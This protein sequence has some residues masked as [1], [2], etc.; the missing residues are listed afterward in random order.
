MTADN[1]TLRNVMWTITYDTPILD[2]SKPLDFVAGMQ[3]TAWI[4][5]ATNIMTGFT[6]NY[7]EEIKF[8]AVA[9]KEK[10]TAKVGESFAADP[11]TYVTNKAGTPR[12]CS[13]SSSDGQSAG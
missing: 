12:G 5:G 13:S 10:Y 7:I 11:A 8:Q 3:G 1:N 4:G 2:M 6:D 9:V